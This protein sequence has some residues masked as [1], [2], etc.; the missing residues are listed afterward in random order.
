MRVN[1]LNIVILYYSPIIIMSPSF[2][3]INKQHHSFVRM[4]KRRRRYDLYDIIKY[5]QKQQLELIR[6]KQ[7]NELLRSF[8]SALSQSTYS[9]SPPI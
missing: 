2:G 1:P 6:K 4:Y 5:V 8:I 3:S 9:Y 7:T